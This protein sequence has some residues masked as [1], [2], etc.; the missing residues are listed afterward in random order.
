LFYAWP[1][2]PCLEEDILERWKGD[3]ALATS[4]GAKLDDDGE[5]FGRRRRAKEATQQQ[6]SQR[7]RKM[8]GRSQR[9]SQSWGDAH[10]FLAGGAL[11]RLG[12]G[13]ARGC[14]EGTAGWIFSVGAWGCGGGRQSGSARWNWEGV[15]IS[16]PRPLQEMARR[17]AAS[18]IAPRCQ[19]RLKLER[20]RRRMSC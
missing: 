15:G 5:R 14:G 1:P 18:T 19:S 3:C 4:R 16:H 9:T 8:G 20:R 10:V 12:S 11:V 13:P 2:A 6:R 7:R 17:P